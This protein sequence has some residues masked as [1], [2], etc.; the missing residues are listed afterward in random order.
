MTNPRRWR[1]IG[2]PG[3]WRSVSVVVVLAAA[4]VSGICW[5]LAS[6]I[7]ASPDDDYHQASIW[8]PVPLSAG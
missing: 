5:S 6:P 7:G 2:V 3:G 1:A 8:R 4:L